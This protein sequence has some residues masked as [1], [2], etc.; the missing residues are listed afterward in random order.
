MILCLRGIFH[1]V[2]GY[3][4]KLSKLS[5]I[6]HVVAIVSF[7]SFSKLYHLLL[8]SRHF[9]PMYV[10]FAIL[11]KNHDNLNDDMSLQ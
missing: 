10:L 9:K 3:F 11:T 5:L 2:D 7:V 6:P 8:T 4:N 1:N